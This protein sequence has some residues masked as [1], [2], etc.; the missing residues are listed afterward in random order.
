MDA[1]VKQAPKSARATEERAVAIAAR[2]PD[3]RYWAM[4]VR[5]MMG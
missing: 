5:P 2:W 4:E 3:A 1:P